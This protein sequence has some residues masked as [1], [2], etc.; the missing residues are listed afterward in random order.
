MMRIAVALGAIIVAAGIFL[1]LRGGDGHASDR[2][3]IDYRDEKF[4]LSK[5]YGDYDDYKN[6]P[7]NLNESEIPRIEKIMTQVRIG[8]EFADWA[9]F[10][11]QAFKIKFPGYGM[12]PG[13]KVAAIDREFQVAV[14]EIPHAG[15]NRY[16]VLEKIDSG[17]L[18]LVDDFVESGG[19]LFSS[20]PISSIHFLD[21]KLVYT[22]RASKIVRETP[23]SP[24]R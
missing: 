1:S 12:G 19:N 9:D 8:P 15:K 16:F 10:T 20:S 22:D 13:P 2:A 11:K 23:L 7:Q 24:P 3:E 21:G 5:D 17:R 18:L 4:K 14:I 6:D